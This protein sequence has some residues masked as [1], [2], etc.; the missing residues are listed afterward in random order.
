MREAEPHI[1]FE[2]RGA[3]GLVTLNRPKALNALTHGMCIGLA[4]TL[5]EWAADGAIRAVAIRGAGPRAFCAGG[6]IRALWESSRDKTANGLNFLRDE[7][8]L[9]AAIAAFPKPYIALWHGIV[10]GGGAGVSV[11]GRYRL[12]DASLMFA[13]PET[14]IGFVTDIGATF[15]LS[16]LAGEAGLYLALTGARIGRDDAVALGLAT[17]VVDVADHDALIENLAGAAVAE[18]AIAA[19]ARKPAAPP[20]KREAARIDRTF[21]AHTVEAILERLERDGSDFA[22]ATAQ[23]IRTRSPSA[24]KFTFRA[25]R[26]AKALPL[27]DCLKMEYRIAARAVPAP[28]FREGVRAAIIDKDGKPAWVPASLAGISETDIA[29]YFASLGARELSFR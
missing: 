18:D 9:N 3:L 5:D 23:T 11:H 4:K 17:H 7:Y 25:L 6:D 22:I 29:G 13:M 28:D 2:K 26:E 19:F 27:R 14:G 10:M 1:L 21:A 20:L 15:F 16:R 24:C 8:R 12:A